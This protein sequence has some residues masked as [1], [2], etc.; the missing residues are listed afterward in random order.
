MSK[1]N[2]KT[3]KLPKS[4]VSS[5]WPIIWELLRINNHNFMNSLTQLS[6]NRHELHA[7]KIM[8]SPYA[9]RQRMMDRW[10]VLGWIFYA[11]LRK[12][13]KY[14]FHKSWK[15][16]LLIINDHIFNMCLTTIFIFNRIIKRV[17][18]SL[19]LNVMIVVA[20]NY[21]IYVIPH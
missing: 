3:R 15:M 13:T 1:F 6:N 7:S 8:N 5:E 19:Y 20:K 4:P 16:S 10:K 12:L 11:S 9:L 21:L 14:Y 17:C 18:L 2:E